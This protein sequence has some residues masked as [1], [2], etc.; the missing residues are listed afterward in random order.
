MSRQTSKTSR[1]LIIPVGPSAPSRAHGSN[2]LAPSAGLLPPWPYE[3]S[4]V[5]VN[6]GVTQLTL[7][8]SCLS[9]CAKATVYELAAALDVLYATTWSDESGLAWY[10]VEAMS[11]VTLR[12][13]AWEDFRRSGRNVVVVWIRPKKLGSK[14]AR[15]SATSTVVAF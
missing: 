3:L 7:I 9:S 5:D 13:T 4:L 11:V 12:I 10:V 8:P 6:P 15:T 14:T 1:R 2:V